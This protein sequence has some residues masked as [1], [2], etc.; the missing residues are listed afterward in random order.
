MQ[1]LIQLAVFYSAASPFKN[2]ILRVARHEPH[3]VCSTD[4]NLGQGCWGAMSLTT[5]LS[6]PSIGKKLHP[7][8]KYS[9]LTTAD[10][11][12]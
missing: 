7:S 11:A 6:T 8:G 12:A 10:P 3:I 5:A 9:V 4:L 2:F 1:R